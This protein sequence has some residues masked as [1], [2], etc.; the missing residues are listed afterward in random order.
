MSSRAT[1][2]TV[3]LVA[4]AAGGTWWVLRPTTE[5]VVDPDADAVVPGGGA[6][7]FRPEPAKVDRA[8]TPREAV[9]SPDERL[10]IVEPGERPKVRIP[11]A[12]EDGK[13]R[14]DDVRRALADV[15]GLYL[16]WQDEATRAAFVDATIEVPKEAYEPRDRPEGADV[17]TILGT[18]MRA[19]F[20]A[21]IEGAALVIRK[22]RRP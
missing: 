11:E 4:A 19:G 6:P 5:S 8:P 21:R 2:L 17:G 13:A 22:V 12:G 20:H 1:L 7:A 9:F 14:G 15:P 18:L 10:P 16:R 3:L